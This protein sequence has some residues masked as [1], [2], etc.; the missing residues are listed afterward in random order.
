[1]GNMCVRSD[2]SEDTTISKFA[3]GKNY[4]ELTGEYVGEGIKRTFAWE[5]E[6]SRKGL[7]AKRQE[8]WSSRT[9]GSRHAWNAIKAA[10]DADEG[11]AALLL[12]SANIRLENDSLTLC[13]DRHGNKYEVPIFVINDPK[14]FTS[15]K[16]A[17]TKIKKLKENTEIKLKIRCFQLSTTDVII[18]I[19]NSKTILDLKQ[20]YIKEQEGVF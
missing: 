18:T 6:I 7:D 10:V 9:E 1:M 12:E 11:T 19:N 3:V 2:E 5:T 17:P 8:F 13:W 4:K 16:L 15:G 20:A 14:T